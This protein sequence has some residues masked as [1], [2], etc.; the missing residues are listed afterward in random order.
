MSYHD[1]NTITELLTKSLVL[2]ALL[3]TFLLLQLNEA[4]YLH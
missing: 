3:L 2:T 4:L 1:Q